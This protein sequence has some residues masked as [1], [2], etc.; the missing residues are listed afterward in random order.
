MYKRMKMYLLYLDE[1]LNHVVEGYRKL[2]F[3]Y[4]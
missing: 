4:I 3:L 1:I 2:N